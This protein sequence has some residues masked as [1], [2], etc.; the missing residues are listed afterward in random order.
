MILRN[1]LHFLFELVM[2]SESGYNHEACMAHVE[3][4][5][6]TFLAEIQSFLEDVRSG[7]R[8]PSR[9]AG[10]RDGLANLAVVEACEDSLKNNMPVKVMHLM[11]VKS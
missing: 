4:Y 2:A 5:E 3:R 10:F 6:P 7:A 11:T 1:I 8:T 9:G